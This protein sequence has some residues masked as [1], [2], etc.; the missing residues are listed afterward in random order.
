MAK[1]EHKIAN[2]KHTIKNWHSIVMHDVPES[3]SNN[4]Y[5]IFIYKYCWLLCSLLRTGLA[6]ETTAPTNNKT[7]NNKILTELRIYLNQQCG[8]HG[9][10]NRLRFVIDGICVLY[11]HV[12]QTQQNKWEKHQ[13]YNN[14]GM[15][16]YHRVHEL[17]TFVFTYF[18]G[19]ISLLSKMTWKK[20]GTSRATNQPTNEASGRTTREKKREANPTSVFR[21]SYFLTSRSLTFV[22]SVHSDNSTDN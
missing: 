8:P 10:N 11:V 22:N 2:H 6:P 3:F 13:P 19:K 7:Y 4:I 15:Q 18:S 12:V 21:L 9:Y 5:L 20:L 14:N 17:S 16:M 1:Y